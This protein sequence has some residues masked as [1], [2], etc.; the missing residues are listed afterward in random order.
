M[1]KKKIPHDPNEVLA[2]VNE[3]DEII[4]KATRKEIHTSGVL[5]RE[6]CTYIMNSKKEL[7]MQRR[8]D[9]GYWDD[10]ASGHFPFDSTYE[11]AA[12]R[13]LFEEL[14]LK[15]KKE[16]LIFIAKDFFH[17]TKKINNRIGQ[18]FLIKKDV[19]IK[20]LNIDPDEVIEAKYFNEKEI[21]EMLNKENYITE[22]TSKILKKYLIGNLYKY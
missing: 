22:M 12:V 2:I 4:G 1:D 19:K 7:L 17:S 18:V 15:I 20:D 14:G 10:S 11:E 3:N 16:E 21:R 9:N 13:E 5:H 6:V 8:K